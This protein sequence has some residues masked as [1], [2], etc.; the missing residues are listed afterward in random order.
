[1]IFVLQN[2]DKALVPE[3]S[4]VVYTVNQLSYCKRQ[5]FMK[6]TETSSQVDI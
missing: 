4:F 1:M 5:V 3:Q 2:N 6:I